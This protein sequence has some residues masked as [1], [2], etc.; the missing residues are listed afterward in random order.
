VFSGFTSYQPFG[1][2]GVHF[3]SEAGVSAT[4]ATI[5]GY[6]LRRGTV[7]Y[8]GLPGFASR[9]AHDVDAKELVNQVW[10]VLDR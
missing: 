1:G 7:V 3:A 5:I 6:R 10:T 2:S 9:L 4:A 8:V